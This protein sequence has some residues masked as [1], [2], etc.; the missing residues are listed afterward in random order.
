MVVKVAW[1]PEDEALLRRLYPT[2][3]TKVIAAQLGR[4]Q[5]A[6]RTRAME[7]GIT[8]NVEKPSG[9]KN[10]FVPLTREETMKRDKIDL[11]CV[12]WSLLE[13]Y[14]REL[15]NPELRT[16]DRIRLM[17]AMSSHTATISTVMRGSED[18]LGAED[19][20][21]TQFLRLEFDKVDKITPRRIRF[22]RRIYD[23]VD[24]RKAVGDG[25]K[26]R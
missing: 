10:S 2:T 6:L 24:G 19:D 8:K 18:Q 7:L 26:R 17:H 1:T 23:L 20:L 13:M 4:T 21:K 25:P 15:A 16:R 9:F 11:L 12:N 5:V 22:G 14:Q 3:P